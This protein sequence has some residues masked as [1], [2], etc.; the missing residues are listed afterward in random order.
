MC[1]SPIERLDVLY[2][3]PPEPLP[4][5]VLGTLT[6]IGIQRALW[7]KTLGTCSVKQSKTSFF[8]AELLRSSTSLPNL[9]GG[10]FQTLVPRSSSPRS[11]RRS[12][13]ALW[14]MLWEAVIPEGGAVWQSP[15]RDIE[16]VPSCQRARLSGGL[17][18]EGSRPRI[19]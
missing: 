7:L 14:E 8:I 16:G 3:Q 18:G 1:F 5:G 15:V 2:A 10:Y 11:A 19:C 6:G 4:E 9:Q 12:Q 13:G 17:R